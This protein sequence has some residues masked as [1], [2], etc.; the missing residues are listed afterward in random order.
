MQK[1]NIELRCSMEQWRQ[2]RSIVINRLQ[3]SSPKACI[4]V[5]LFL[6]Y[7]KQDQQE[8]LKKMLLLF[9]SPDTEQKE[10]MTQ[11]W[12]DGRVKAVSA[13]LSLTLRDI[14]CVK[15]VQVLQ[16]DDEVK[17]ATSATHHYSSI[18]LAT[19]MERLED[20]WSILEASWSILSGYK[21]GHVE[22]KDNHIMDM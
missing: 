3:Q 20:K 21:E 12:F 15:H 22:I 13:K 4:K 9:D 10:T 14:L 11:T 8:F 1:M 19:I 6:E 16:L 18:A 7:P 17:I 5:R 2:I